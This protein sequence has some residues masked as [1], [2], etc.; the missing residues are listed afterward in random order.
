MLRLDILVPKLAYPF[1]V[2]LEII[3]G[4]A[5]IAFNPDRIAAKTILSATYFEELISNIIILCMK[6]DISYLYPPTVSK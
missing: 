6:N 4:R 5:T 3:P 1:M 2:E